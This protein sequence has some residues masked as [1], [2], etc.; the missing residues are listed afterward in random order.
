[1]AHDEFD[2]LVEGLDITNRDEGAAL[3]VWSCLLGSFPNYA[4]YLGHLADE[5][6]EELLMELAVRINRLK[7]IQSQK[8]DPE[9]YKNHLLKEAFE[10]LKL[11]KTSDGLF[12]MYWKPHLHSPPSNRVIR[13]LLQFM[14]DYH[15]TVFEITQDVERKRNDVLIG[16]NE[17]QSHLRW[18]IALKNFNDHLKDLCVIQDHLQY[19]LIRPEE[20]IV[21]NVK[22][23]I[24]DRNR[25]K[26]NEKY[27]EIDPKFQVE[28]QTGKRFEE[29]VAELD[30]ARRDKRIVFAVWHYLNEGNIGELTDQE[31]EEFLVELAVR[32]DKL[33]AFLKQRSDPDQYEKELLDLSKDLLNINQI[34]QELSYEYSEPKA[35]RTPSDQMIAVLQKRIEGYYDTLSE[36]EEVVASRSGEKAIWSVISRRFT[37][38]LAKLE[39]MQ[40]NLYE[41]LERTDEKAEDEIGK[42]QDYVWKRRPTRDRRGRRRNIGGK[43]KRAMA[44]VPK[45]IDN[46]TKKIFKR[47]RDRQR[48]GRE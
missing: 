16:K 43:F 12:L 26:E 36:L 32:T 37:E 41:Y 10:L 47:L 48:E 14:G 2:K 27:E 35:N 30:L 39:K 29:I 45:I 42:V 34:L 21:K 28:S 6:I 23:Y 1:M 19:Y 44:K 8:A 46:A 4:D 3:F 5:E 17:S 33:K 24:K 11:K 20:N 40:V 13:S 9:G 22:D 38:H 31:M 15:E 18:S 25:T 7:E